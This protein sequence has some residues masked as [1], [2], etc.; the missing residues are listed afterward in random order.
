MPA[1]IALVL[2][3]LVGQADAANQ[4][5]CYSSP[6][7][8]AGWVAWQTVDGKRCWYVGRRRID[9]SLLYWE[10]E[11]PIEVEP[12]PLPT[13]EPP[14]RAQDSEFEDRWNAQ[15]DHRTAR[16]PL[17]MQQWRMWE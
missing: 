8:V 1:L 4:I 11:Q 12:M 17:P 13:E 2:F 16:D 7:Q 6:P 9:K 15:Y 10:R 3:L 14:V 5:K